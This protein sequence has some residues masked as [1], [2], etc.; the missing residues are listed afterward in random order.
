MLSVG[1]GMII[2]NDWAYVVLMPPIDGN[3]FLVFKGIATR[4]R[5]N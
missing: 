5:T 2:E 3:Q 4:L 1:Y